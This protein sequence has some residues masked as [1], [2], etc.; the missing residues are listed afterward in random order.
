LKSSFPLPS[1]S[2]FGV[3]TAVVN[4]SVIARMIENPDV[5]RT[6][7]T[8]GVAFRWSKVCKVLGRY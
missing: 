5:E 7:R 1:G 6:I 4:I 2:D 3:E 8:E